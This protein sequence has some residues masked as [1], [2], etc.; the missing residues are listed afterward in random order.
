MNYFDVIISEFLNDGAGG[1]HFLKTLQLL[2]KILH[3]S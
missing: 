1:E 3:L 2:M